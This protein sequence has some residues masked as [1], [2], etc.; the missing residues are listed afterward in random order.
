MITGQVRTNGGVSLNWT[1]DLVETGLKTQTGGRIK[2]LAP[3]IGNEN[4]W[5]RCLIAVWQ[6]CWRGELITRE[7]A[8]RSDTKQLGN[9]ERLRDG[10]VF[11]QPSHSSFPNH[12]DCFDA[13]PSSPPSHNFATKPV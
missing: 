8:L 12:M 13:L 3:W 5:F 7:L 2:R 6:G 11:G 10:I 9:E 4:L 1:V